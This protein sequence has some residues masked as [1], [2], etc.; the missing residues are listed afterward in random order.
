MKVIPLLKNTI[1]KSME[2]CV[3]PIIK[4]NIALNAFESRKTE[5]RGD[6]K[7]RIDFHLTALHFP[8]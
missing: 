1:N 2:Q 7:L 5:L 8:K 6:D 4:K 3:I